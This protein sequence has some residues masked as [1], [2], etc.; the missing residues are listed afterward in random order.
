MKNVFLL[1]LVITVLGA[2]ANKQ[3]NFSVTQISKKELSQEF[4]YKG[5]F[6]QA[7]QWKDKN[8]KN[9]LILST[10]N[11]L[12]KVEDIDDSASTRELFARQYVVR[13][14]VNPKILWEMYDFENSCTVDLT[15]EFIGVPTFTD[16]DNDSI[17]ESFIIYRLSCRGD[18]SP[19]TM[20]V[21]E[22]EG[23]NKYALRGRMY[24]KADEGSPEALDMK[25]WE[26]DLSKITRS[27]DDWKSADGRYENAND[28]INA[29]PSFLEKAKELWMENVNEKF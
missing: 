15:A 25:T 23:K 28:F 10:N 11:K 5:S 2:C 21:I 22:H 3:Q 18:I 4:T 13:K 7:W 9:I 12:V 14:D 16:L 29:P 17:A 19:S 6:L 20:K 24:V 8:G 27:K 1:F 26:P